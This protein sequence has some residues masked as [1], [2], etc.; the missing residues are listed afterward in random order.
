MKLCEGGVNPPDI[1]GGG[2]DPSPP[3]QKPCYIAKRKALYTYLVASMSDIF[4]E[5]AAS[6]LFIG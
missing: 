3:R 1:L 5:V 4:S 6:F 2:G